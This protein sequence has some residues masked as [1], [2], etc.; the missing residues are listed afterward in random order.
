MDPKCRPIR[1]ASV[2]LNMDM[3]GYL[4]DLNLIGIRKMF[5]PF[6]NTAKSKA[7]FRAAF[8]IEAHAEIQIGCCPESPQPLVESEL[9]PMAQFFHTAVEARL[10][11]QVDHCMCYLAKDRTAWNSQT[12]LVILINHHIYNLNVIQRITYT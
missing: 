4:K 3:R 1:L 7:E 10:I 12:R 6:F 5:A 8:I 9:V 11:I 2:W